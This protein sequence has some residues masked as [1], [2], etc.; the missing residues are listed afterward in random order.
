[1]FLLFLPLNQVAHHLP[2]EH[3]E[4]RQDDFLEKLHPL[5]QQTFLENGH[6]EDE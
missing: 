5:L 4:V 2:E 1:M 6:L 3:T